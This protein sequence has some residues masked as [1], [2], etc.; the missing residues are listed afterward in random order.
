TLSRALREV[1]G[2]QV[3]DQTPAAELPHVRQSS[4]MT[5]TTWR[6]RAAALALMAAAAAPNAFAAGAP[7]DG[8]WPDYG[9]DGSQQHHSPLPQITTSDIGQLGLAWPFQLESGYSLS[10][11]V[12]AEGKLFVTSGHSHIRAFDAVT[13][14]MLW[15]YDAKVRELAPTPLYM[16]W[17]SK[18]LA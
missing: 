3:A 6:Q 17:G 2:W 11:P 1:P 12:A 18:G 14:K 13:G 9:R 4:R 7:V 16:T 8:D 10:T 5:G 15:E